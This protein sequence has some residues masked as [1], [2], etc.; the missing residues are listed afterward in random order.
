[1]ISEKRINDIEEQRING[2]PITIQSQLSS[3]SLHNHSG[4]FHLSPNQ[5]NPASYISQEPYMATILLP[6]CSPNDKVS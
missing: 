2:P 1:M 5:E 6:I 3:V 4:L